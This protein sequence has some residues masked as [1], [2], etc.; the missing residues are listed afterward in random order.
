MKSIIQKSPTATAVVL[1]FISIVL[2]SFSAVPGGD[3]F[4][5][6]VNNKLVI[7]EHL[8]GRKE[9]ARLVVNQ[10]SDEQ[11]SVEFNN[12]GKINT[13]RKLIIKDGENK[14]VKKWDFADSPD[15]KNQM[16]FKV[17][18]ISALSEKTVNLNLYYVSNEVSNGQ[19]LA[20]INLTQKTARR[21]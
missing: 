1:A 8:Y 2:S 19:L 21:E 14:I 4:R 15:L 11:V 5:I 9:T 13:A 18:E 12:C 10:E 7:Q 20:S 6:Y 3:S 16:S 17:R